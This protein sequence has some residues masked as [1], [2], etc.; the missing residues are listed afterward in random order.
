MDCTNELRIGLAS[1]VNWFSVKSTG[2]ACWELVSVAWNGLVYSKCA[3]K[4]FGDVI[5]FSDFIK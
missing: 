3:V 4:R 5:G 1:V 2:L